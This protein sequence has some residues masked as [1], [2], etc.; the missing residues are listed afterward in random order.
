MAAA[1]C[2]RA[3]WGPG[4]QGALTESGARGAQQAILF[5]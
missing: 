5:Q 2:E 3:E 4:E 1:G